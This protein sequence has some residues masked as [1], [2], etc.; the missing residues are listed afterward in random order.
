MLM[1]N[2]DIQHGIKHTYEWQKSHH[3]TEFH[4][5]G[6]G[7]PVKPIAPGGP[8]RASYRGQ[9]GQQQFSQGSTEHN[10]TPVY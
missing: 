4:T 5:R 7:R 3:V 10:N 1:M 9:K 2:I 6:P 8:V